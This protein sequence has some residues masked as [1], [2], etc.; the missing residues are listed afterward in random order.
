[1]VIH[2]L[3]FVTDNKPLLGLFHE[4]QAVPAQDSS[5]IQRWALA[6]AM[7]EYQLMHRKSSEHANADAFS[8]L[9]LPECASF[10]PQPAET[11]LLMEQMQDSPVASDHIKTWTH[12]DPVLSQVIQFARNSWSSGSIEK[13]LRPYWQ[14]RLELSVQEDCLLWG[15][16][17]VIPTAG[18]A[19]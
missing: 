1:M 16:H 11:V 18:G 3:I 15:N 2:L 9:P 10:T 13:P 4:K 8:C 6:L 19:T 12:R 7:Y 17:V 5:Q 14:K